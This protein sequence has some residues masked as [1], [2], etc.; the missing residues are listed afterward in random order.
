MS[1]AA[2]KGTNKGSKFVAARPNR[3]EWD[4]TDV[5]TMVSSAVGNVAVAPAVTVLTNIAGA[6]A[7]TREQPHD[8]P[9]TGFQVNSG[10]DA[11]QRLRSKHLPENLF[12]PFR[13]RDSRRP[14]DALKIT[15][16]ADLEADSQQSTR[17]L[18]HSAGG[19]SAAAEHIKGGIR[20][21]L[22]R[23]ALQTCVPY[24]GVCWYCLHEIPCGC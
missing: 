22:D 3:G 12:N 18:H 1:C 9:T 19:T 15:Q 6:V 8:T 4:A 10:L 14:I 20:E 11:G 5:D 21:A 13:R 23:W 24:S 17:E 2:K 16:N 7:V